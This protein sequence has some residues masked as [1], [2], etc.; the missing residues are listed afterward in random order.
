MTYGLQAFEIVTMHGRIIFHAAIQLLGSAL[1]HGISHPSWP[2]SSFLKILCIY[3][4]RYR[5]FLASAEELETIS[6]VGNPWHQRSIPIALPSEGFNKGGGNPSRMHRQMYAAKD[7]ECMF[8]IYFI[9]GCFTTI[10][11]RNSKAN[12]Q[13][14]LK[15]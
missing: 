14:L 3:S 8:L 7:A 15:D 6:G 9:P 10:E 11:C 4:G 1:D 12:Q 13:Y 2:H 5:S